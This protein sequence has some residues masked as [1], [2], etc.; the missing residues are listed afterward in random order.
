LLV[1]AALPST[2]LTAHAPAAKDSGGNRK[3]AMPPFPND[4]RQRDIS[5]LA[6]VLKLGFALTEYTYQV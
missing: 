6:V 1:C 2:L 5:W 4:D 3:G